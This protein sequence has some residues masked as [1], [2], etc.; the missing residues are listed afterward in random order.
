MGWRYRLFSSP[1]ATSRSSERN[2]KLPWSEK[3]PRIYRVKSGWT[4][5][6]RPFMNAL[7]FACKLQ[8]FK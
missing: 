8:S 1:P 3:I 7:T 5:K 2:V 4:L 6:G